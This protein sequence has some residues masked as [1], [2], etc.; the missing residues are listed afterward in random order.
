MN[1]LNFYP[2]EVVSRYRD[3]QL[4]VGENYTYLFNLRLKIRKSRFWG[5]KSLK[6]SQIKQIRAIFTHLKLWVTEPRHNVKTLKI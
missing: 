4:Q 5:I 2:F 3:P 6:D 1:N